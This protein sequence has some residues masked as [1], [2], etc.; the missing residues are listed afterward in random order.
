MTKKH[1]CLHSLILALTVGLSYAAVKTWLYF[2][3][4]GLFLLVVS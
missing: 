3:T 2:P 1:N 4:P